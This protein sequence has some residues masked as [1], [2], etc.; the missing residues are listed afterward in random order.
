[1]DQST[2]NTTTSPQIS[3]QSNFQIFDENN[4]PIPICNINDS[5]NNSH[6]FIGEPDHFQK[7]LKDMLSFKYL[8]IVSSV[9][10]FIFVSIFT[11]N[12]GSS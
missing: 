10:L 12:F 3:S 7:S 5:V 6:M 4:R 1:M 9:L 8:A 11:L 2:N